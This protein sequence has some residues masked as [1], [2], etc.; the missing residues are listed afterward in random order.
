[1]PMNG[2]KAYRLISRTADAAYRESDATRIVRVGDV[3]VGGAGS[4]IIAGPCAVESR[5]QTLE[6]ALAVKAVGADMLRGGAY[7]PR[8]SPYD[9]QGLGE[10]GLKI[11][12]EAKA[13]TG[14]P[15]VTEVID[16][17]L[18]ASVAA[19]ADVL[20]IGSRNMQNFPLLTEVG[21][22]GKP[23]LLKRGITAT[24]TEWL[25]AAEYIAKEGNL[26]IILCERGVRTAMSGRYDRFTLDL[27][28]IGAV[29]EQ[30]FLPII[31]DPSHSSGAR[32]RVPDAAKAGIVCGAHGLMIEVI[33]ERTDPC[34]IRCDGAQGIRP[35]TL[36]R[37][38]SD[39]G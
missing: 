5:E 27:N 12:S 23:V 37:I 11:L 26:D 35:S 6:I 25:C 30:T 22:T 39:L 2:N 13:Q 15:I 4:V 7:K 29:K 18:V 10:E 3:A 19:Y 20:Q 17:R 14:L 9:F 24:L 33:G 16:T 38:L 1:M 32:N 34:T 21:R 28:V 31:V 36:R 8:T